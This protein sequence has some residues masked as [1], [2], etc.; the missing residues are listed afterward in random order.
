MNGVVC[1]STEILCNGTPATFQHTCSST[2]YVLISFLRYY[3]KSN[4]PALAKFEWKLQTKNNYWSYIFACNINP[5]ARAGNGEEIEQ[6]GEMNVS[7]YPNPVIKG[8]TL[9]LNIDSETISDATVYISNMMG[10]VVIKNEIEI[11]EMNNEW[12]LPIDHLKS[13]NYMVS[14]VSESG[15]YSKPLIIQ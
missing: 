11:E 5:A 7:L 1:G 2:N 9:K 12:M 10:Q 8:N 4:A 6:E 14:V 3:L 13:G 15:R